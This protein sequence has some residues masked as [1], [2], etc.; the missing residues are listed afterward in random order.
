MQQI[1]NFLIRNKTFI[2]FLMLLALS[3]AF[4]IQSHSYHRSKFINSANWLSGGV[5]GTVNNIND[6]FHLRE[7]NEQLASENRRLRNMIFNR[8]TFPS[9][10]LEID[11]SI[12][13]KFIFRNASIIKN[14]YDKQ[15]NYLLIDKG[16]NDSIRQDMGVVSSDG[17]VGIID[18]TS[19]GYAT[20]QSVLNTISEIN[21]SV[22]NTNNFGSLQ[23]DGKSANVVQL[24]DILSSAPI[25][26]GD[27]IITGGMSSIFPKGILIGRIK[28]FRPDVS[29]NYY[30]IDV[31]LFND[32]TTLDKVYVIENTDR[33]EISNLEALTNEQ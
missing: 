28:D 18:N 14:S 10:S 13:G 8:E 22:K 11:S 27:T 2:I 5:Y 19:A 33:E 7:Y 16:H 23:W 1:I 9:D 29:E 3:L 4:T 24:V 12:A 6:Y 15:R 32:M 25:K 21:A 26:P 31:E 20:V 30:I 17:L